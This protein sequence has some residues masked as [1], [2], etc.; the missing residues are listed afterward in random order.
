MNRLGKILTL[1]LEKKRAWQLPII[2]ALLVLFGLGVRW[3][4][5]SRAAQGIRLLDMVDIGDLDGVRWICRWDREQV[6]EEGKVSRVYKW[7]RMGKRPSTSKL[8]PLSLAA[9]GGYIDIAKTLIKT[10]A[11]VNARVKTIWLPLYSAVA[12][13]YTELAK[14]L[15]EAGADVNAKTKSGWTALHLTAWKGHP[16]TVKLLLA[17]GA[18]VNAKAKDGWTPLHWATRRGKTETVK[19]LLAAGAEVNAKDKDGNTPLDFA[20]EEMR[21][22][23]REHGARTRRELNAE[24]EQGKKQ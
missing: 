24:A 16:E 4:F 23:L 3:W 19:L 17:A 12:R 6:N 21:Q 5:N 7:D 22:L 18:E 14:M 8:L 2:A 15:I 1:G 10:G 9:R 13:G 20:V 11:E